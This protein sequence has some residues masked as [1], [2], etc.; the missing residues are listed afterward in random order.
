MFKE[1]GWMVLAKHKGYSDK[2]HKNVMVLIEH[3]KKI[4]SFKKFE[5]IFKINLYQTNLHKSNFINKY[6][7][8]KPIIVIVEDFNDPIIPK[9]HKKKAMSSEKASHVKIAGHTNETNFVALIGGKVIPGHTKPDAEKNGFKFSLKKECKR[10]QFALYS[11]NS[12]YWNISSPSSMLCKEILSIYP[13][14]FAEYQQNKPHYKGLLREKMVN[15]KNHLSDLDNLKDYLR[16]IITNVDEVHYMVFQD[17]QNHYIFDAVQ[18]IDI[19]AINARVE[20]SKA[21]KVGDNPEQKVVIKTKNSQDKFR[22]LIELEIR[23]SG[24]N[25]YAEFLAVCNR[26]NLLNLLKAHIPEE[27][28]FKDIVHFSEVLFVRGNAIANFETQVL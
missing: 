14:S 6:I 24:N 21:L 9:I 19:I 20:N 22:N 13:S 1:L 10:I 8:Q 28:I 2:I 26:D 18:V 16:F 23:N 11:R 17:G 25:H 27:K 15:L 7:M 3:A 4:Y 5:L 12:S